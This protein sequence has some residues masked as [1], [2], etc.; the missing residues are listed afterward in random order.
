M[1]TILATQHGDQRSRILDAEQKAKA[2]LEALRGQRSITDIAQDWGVDPSELLKWQCTLVEGAAS[3]FGKKTPAPQEEL[4]RVRQVNNA[5]I[6][7][8]FE[9]MELRESLQLSAS[10]LHRLLAYQEEVK[11]QERKRIAKEIHDELG[12]TLLAIRLD[13]AMLQDRTRVRHPHLHRRVGMV[14]DN[15]DGAIQSVKA[16]INELRPFELELGLPA[17]LN[18][19]V[20]RF[21]RSAGIATSLQIEDFPDDGPV[22]ADTIILAFFRLLQEGLNNVARHARASEVRIRLKRSE[23]GIEMFVNDNGV[24]T[25]PASLRASKGFGL[26]ALAERLKDLDGTLSVDTPLVGGTCLYGFIPIVDLH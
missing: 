17:A 22:L 6:S 16:M 5:L 3:L 20:N 12:Q 19:Q 25:T 9:Q 14:I 7:T 2:A 8:V 24:G 13:I 23:L 18:W 11:E 1:K 26:I 10:S 15:I 21:Q 4:V